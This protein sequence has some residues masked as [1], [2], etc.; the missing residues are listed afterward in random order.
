ME[1][2]ELKLGNLVIWGAHG[3]CE[4]I[5]I[6]KEKIRVQVFNSTAGYD[7][8][9][10]FTSDLEPVILS[11]GILEDCGFEEDSD[12]SQNLYRLGGFILKNEGDYESWIFCIVN[13]VVSY[14]PLKSLHFLQNLYYSL[15]SGKELDVSKILFNTKV[16][17]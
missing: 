2:K 1:A 9:L 17:A 6:K 14:T 10:V 12:D 15:T 11:P 4:V 7:K 8:V 5:E 13:Q 3:I 16:H